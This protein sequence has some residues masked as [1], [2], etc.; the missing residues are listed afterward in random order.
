MQQLNLDTPLSVGEIL[1]RSSAAGD[2]I[3]DVSQRLIALA[4]VL[5]QELDLEIRSDV[6]FA[7]LAHAD[8][9]TGDTVRGAAH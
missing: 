5:V 2:R 7:M 8:Y 9:L 1:A 4:A 3:E 6:A